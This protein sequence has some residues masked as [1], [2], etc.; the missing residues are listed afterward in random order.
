M[1]TKTVFQSLVIIA[2]AATC[3]GAQTPAQSPQKEIDIRI[4]Q[5]YSQLARILSGMPIRW[6]KR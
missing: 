4:A 3:M 1:Q 6:R 5:I 2:F